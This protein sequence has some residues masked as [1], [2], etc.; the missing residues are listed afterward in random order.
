MNSAMI[1]AALDEQIDRLGKARALLTG[2]TVP[3]KRG[4][5]KRKLS[6]EARARIAAAQKRRWADQK[7][8]S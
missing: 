8:L 5:F 6:A 7:S 3:L 1:V 4:R 2:H